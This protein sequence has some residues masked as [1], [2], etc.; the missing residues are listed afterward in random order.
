[1]MQD[2]LSFD[3]SSHLDDQIF[4]AIYWTR[5]FTTMFETALSLYHVLSQQTKIHNVIREF[6]KDQF[7]SN[8]FTYLLY[9]V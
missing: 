4:L 2:M 9:L 3:S 8:I 6:Y 5:D 7:Q 1:M